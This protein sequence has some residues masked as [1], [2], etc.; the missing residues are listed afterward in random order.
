[1]SFTTIAGRRDRSAIA[2]GDP[3]AYRQMWM[4]D[5]GPARQ[6]LSTGMT[7]MLFARH[8]RRRKS[9]TRE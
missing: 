4:I 1:M 2:I 6:T 8:G 9:Q 3:I 7:S 5:N